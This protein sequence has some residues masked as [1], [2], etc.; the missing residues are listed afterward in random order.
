MNGESRAA[1]P[2]FRNSS[3]GHSTSAAEWLDSAAL[4]AWLDV[5]ERTLERWRY[6]GGGPPYYRLGRLVRYRRSLVEVWLAER[7]VQAEPG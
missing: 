2:G 3:V 4:A 5:P 7:R 1:R 6:T